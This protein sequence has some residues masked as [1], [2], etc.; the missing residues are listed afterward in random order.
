MLFSGEARVTGKSEKGD[1]LDLTVIWTAL[2]V[3][4]NGQWKIRML[5]SLPKPS[6]QPQ[7]AAAK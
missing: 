6:P 1:P 5:T 4:E 3:R 2:D 7:E